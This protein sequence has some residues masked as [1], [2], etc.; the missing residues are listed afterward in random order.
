MIEINKNNGIKDPNRP[1][2]ANNCKNVL[3][4]CDVQANFEE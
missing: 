2:S 4:G 1:V 3:C